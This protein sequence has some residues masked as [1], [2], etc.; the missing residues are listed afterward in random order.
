MLKL[1]IGETELFNEEDSTF[2]SVDGIVIELEHS[3]I[4]LSK[5]E[6]KYKVPFLAKGTKTTEEVLD[7]IKMMILTPN[8]PEDILEKFSGK[9]IVEVNTY[10]ESKE[11]ATT[12]GLMPEHKGKGE[13]IT[14][15]LIYYWLVVYN[16]PFE[17]ETWHLNRLFSLIRICNVKQ[18]KPKK[19]S[20][21]ARAA[22][23]R[24]INAQ[25]KASLGT[26]G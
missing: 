26:T 9:N 7:Y 10:I 2:T 4:S 25:R 3:L 15:E 17:V 20:K 1:T 16:I 14:A 21:S 11:S 18:S 5:W 6:S 19:L 24:E 13:A 22:Q 23:M 8:A 12:F